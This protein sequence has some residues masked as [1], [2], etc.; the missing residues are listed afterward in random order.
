M[1]D[2]AVPRLAQA[3]VANCRWWES[4]LVEPVQKPR[5]EFFGSIPIFQ[6]A[7]FQQFLPG[8]VRVHTMRPRYGSVNERIALTPAPHGTGIR[9]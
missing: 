9:P 2:V 7:G 4:S 5:G 6:I 8:S 1:G 3:G